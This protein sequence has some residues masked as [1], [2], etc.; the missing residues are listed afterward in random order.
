MDYEEA[1]K[2]FPQSLYRMRDLDAGAWPSKRSKIYQDLKAGE[3]PQ[4]IYVDG[5]GRCWTRFQLAQELV[6]RTQSKAAKE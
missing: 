3:F 5:V 6:R 2:L 1:L 4:G